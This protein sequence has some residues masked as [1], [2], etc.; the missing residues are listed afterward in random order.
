MRRPSGARRPADVWLMVRESAEALDLA[1]RNDS[2]HLSRLVQR[3]AGSTPVN[4]QGSRWGFRP[5]RASS[6][7]L[8]RRPRAE[9]GR[10]QTG[11]NIRPVEPEAAADIRSVVHT[12][13]RSFCAV[14]AGIHR[15][16]LRV[17]R[18]RRMKPVPLFDREV[19][20]ELDQFVTAR[21]ACP[22]RERALRRALVHDATLHVRL[23]T[24]ERCR[25]REAERLAHAW[26][27]QLGR[28]PHCAARLGEQ[29]Q[30]WHHSGG[31]RRE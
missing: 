29:H 30:L 5:R 23:T 20:A 21:P 28:Q 19:P 13:R 12:A 18:A 9:T 31:Q 3:S 15:F 2:A 27:A 1:V 4:P 8:P 11:R 24:D 17:E 16:L 26:C 22:D 7:A 25:Y 14:V 10:V 6:S